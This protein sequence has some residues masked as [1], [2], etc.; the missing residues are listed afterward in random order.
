MEEVY[1]AARAHSEPDEQRQS[2]LVV[3]SLADIWFPGLDLKGATKPTESA[4]DLLA[5]LFR[6][7]TPHHDDSLRGLARQTFP[8]RDHSIHR[9]LHQT[10]RPL[11]QRVKHELEVRQLTER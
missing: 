5:I 10:E 3:A 9:L 6:W 2:L 4:R 1:A 11:R 8:D 7:S